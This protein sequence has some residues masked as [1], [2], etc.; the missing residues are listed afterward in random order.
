MLDG[1]PLYGPKGDGGVAPTDLDECGGHTD[2]TYPFYHYH[3]TDNF[4]PPYTIKCLVGC[5]FHNFQN[6]AV[7]RLG[8][9]KTSSTCQ[10]ASTQYN[11]SS[12][13]IN[14]V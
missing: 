8:L 7:T 10:A 12:L 5:I 2:R 6:E 4:Q 9:V 11:Y 1:I 3:V 14:W 13:V